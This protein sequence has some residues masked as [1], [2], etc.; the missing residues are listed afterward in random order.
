M[1][2]SF[3]FDTPVQGL[4]KDST[5]TVGALKSPCSRE[6]RGVVTLYIQLC[7]GGM[8]VDAVVCKSFSRDL[9]MYAAFC[10][11]LHRIYRHMWQTAQ[12]IRSSMSCFQLCQCMY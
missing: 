3:A 2:G 10:I 1:C 7:F 6:V 12:L 9:M 11:Q 5:C 4:F 8:Y